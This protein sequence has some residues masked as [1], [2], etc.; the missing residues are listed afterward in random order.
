MKNL[1]MLTY[2]FALLCIGLT[3]CGDDLTEDSLL[4]TENFAA[5]GLSGLD[6]VAASRGSTCFELVFPV[7]ITFEDNSTAT[8]ADQEDLK[9]TVL[10]W[11]QNNTK[12]TDTGDERR[13][14]RGKGLRTEFVYPIQVLNQDGE[15]ID[16]ASS[17]ELKAAKEA[18]GGVRGSKAKK[19]KRG[20]RADKCFSLV[21][22]LTFSFSDGSTQT[23]E[24]AASRKEALKAFKEENGRD[25][26][27]P[28]LAYPI[29]V[30]YADGT[31]A[32]AD[33]SEALQ[34]LKEACSLE[35]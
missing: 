9:A 7:T 3:S 31:Q 1:K 2:L 17:E 4:S 35:G 13:R 21:Y 32:Q 12:T 33:S 6:G 25:A 34:E 30:E 18:C 24:D 28:S 22:P 16:I 14:G 15:T 10:A 5:A 19:G 8:V 20:E 11:K 23:F 27:K 29:T 26:E